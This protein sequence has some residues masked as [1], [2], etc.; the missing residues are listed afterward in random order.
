M[1]GWK[2]EGRGWFERNQG[3]EGGIGVQRRV[4]KTRGRARDGGI[5]GRKRERGIKAGKGLCGR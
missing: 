2:R 1:E 4:K 3:K 5:E